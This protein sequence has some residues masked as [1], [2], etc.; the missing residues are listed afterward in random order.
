MFVKNMDPS[1]MN[2][3]LTF[4]FQISIEFLNCAM[5]FGR[6]YVFL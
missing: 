2:D 4:S 1:R 6:K 3:A 5:V